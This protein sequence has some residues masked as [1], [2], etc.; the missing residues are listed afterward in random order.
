MITFAEFLSESD[1]T[2]RIKWALTK[3]NAQDKFYYDDPELVI[4][5]LDTKKIM[6]HVSS[7]AIGPTGSGAN[8]NRLERLEQHIRTGGYLDPP[9]I[10]DFEREG[11]INFGNGRHRF[12]WAY[13]N[14][15]KKMPFFVMKSEK[16]YMKQK[17]G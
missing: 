12:Y 11:T 4:I 13:K 3:A 15:I 10:G 1:K 14:G 2:P 9:V 6:S 16:E 17:Y 7:T 8:K 5:N